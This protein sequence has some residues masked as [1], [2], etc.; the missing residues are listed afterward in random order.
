MRGA[1][2]AGPGAASSGAEAP[3]LARN[4]YHPR[5][6]RAAAQRPALMRIMCV[7]VS[8]VG[9]RE[10]GGSVAVGIGNGQPVAHQPRK[11]SVLMLDARRR[12]GSA[13][14][15]AVQFNGISRTSPGPCGHIER[16]S[17]QLTHPLFGDPLLLTSPQG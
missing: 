5:G 12:A 6:V 10:R 11:P 16:P 2:P 13:F 17:R 9:F 15:R 7:I 4:A 14:G 3:P 8:A 1:V